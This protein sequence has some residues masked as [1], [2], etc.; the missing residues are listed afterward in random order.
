MLFP[1]ILLCA[2]LMAGCVPRA[3]QPPPMRVLFVGNSLTYVG[4]L[5]A[6]LRALAAKQGRVIETEMLVQG[7]APLSQRVV[8]GSVRALL[9]RERFDH[10][11]LQ[12]RG[13]DL[14]GFQ[15]GAEPSARAHAA[16]VALAREHGAQAWLLGTYQSLPRAS[17]QLHA[18]ESALARELRIGHVAVSEPLRQASAAAPTRDWLQPDFHPGPDLTLF[19]AALLYRALPGVAPDAHALLVAAPP[20][21][22]STG[23]RGDVPE[24]AQRGAAAVTPYRYD[25]ARVAAV[26]ALAVTHGAEPATVTP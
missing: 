26:L 12:E 2:G 19:K 4:N 9:G 17:L 5:P 25:A 10:V 8:D 24:S 22:G 7:G 13:G 1:V 23:L 20:Y 6:T 18:A 15:D 14:A 21:R 16:L 11:V 3:N